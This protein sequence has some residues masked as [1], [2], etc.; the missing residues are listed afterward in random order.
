MTYRVKLTPSKKGPC[1]KI[2]PLTFFRLSDTLKINLTANILTTD[3]DDNSSL[4]PF[5]PKPGENDEKFKDIPFQLRVLDVETKQPIE[6]ARISFS[7]PTLSYRTLKTDRNGFAT[8]NLHNRYEVSASGYEMAKFGISLGCSDSIRTAL[9][10]PYD[11]NKKREFEYFYEYEAQNPIKTEDTLDRITSEI[12]QKLLEPFSEGNYKPNNIVFL[13][14]VSASMLDHERLSLLKS[15]IL[16][17]VELLRPEDI[18]SI[19]TFS[20]ETKI[21]IPPRALTKEIK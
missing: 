8:R 6:G 20:D 4:E 10:A 11:P 2:I 12:E 16:Q 19:I 7:T 13:M 9:L 5:E 18:V 14:D 1:N 15:S 17:L 21:L 3:F